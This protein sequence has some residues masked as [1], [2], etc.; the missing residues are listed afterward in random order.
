MS[1]IQSEKSIGKVLDLLQKERVLYERAENLRKQIVAAERELLDLDRQIIRAQSD[2][3]AEFELMH[4]FPP[5][6]AAPE[7]M[8]V[9]LIELVRQA[10]TAGRDGP[11]AEV[12]KCTTA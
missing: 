11:R 6:T 4:L 2:R 9:F 12:K 3:N 10:Y 7:R 8:N 1:E 5:G